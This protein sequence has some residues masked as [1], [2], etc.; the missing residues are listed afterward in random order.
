MKLV[1]GNYFAALFY[2]GLGVVI[3]F[4]KI[5]LSRKSFSKAES[6]LPNVNI[7][8]ENQRTRSRRGFPL[9]PRYFC[10]QTCLSDVLCCKT[11]SL[12]GNWH[13]VELDG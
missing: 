8:A 11:R 7:L 13:M 1:I 10:K 6:T 3:E 5:K 2:L 9:Q 4:D 12:L